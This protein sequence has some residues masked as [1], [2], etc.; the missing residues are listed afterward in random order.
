MQSHRA[1]STFGLADANVDGVIYDEAALRIIHCSNEG[2]LLMPPAR[3]LSAEG[4]LRLL[5]HCTTAHTLFSVFR[6]ASENLCLVDNAGQDCFQHFYQQ[7]VLYMVRTSMLTCV[8]QISLYHT[9]PDS[10][11]TLI[12]TALCCS[13]TQ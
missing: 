9:T 11:D 8:M 5:I 7:I 1:H 13:S 3:T 12:V 4:A 2:H 6:W 10:T